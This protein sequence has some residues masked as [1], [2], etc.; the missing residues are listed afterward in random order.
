MDIYKNFIDNPTNKGKKLIALN[1]VKNMTIQPTVTKNIIM[2]I[3]NYLYLIELTEENINIDIANNLI[4]IYLD[5]DEENE[6]SKLATRNEIIIRGSLYQIIKINDI[7]NIEKIISTIK[8]KANFHRAITEIK[9]ITDLRKRNNQLYKLLDKLDNETINEQIETISAKYPNFIAKYFSASEYDKMYV[10]ATNLNNILVKNSITN[11]VNVGNSLYFVSVIQQY[12]NQN[13]NY[14]DYAISKISPYCDFKTKP[15]VSYK[16]INQYI[17]HLRASNFFQELIQI[18]DSGE[19]VAL[20]DFT[21]TEGKSLNFF[22]ILIMLA[23]LDHSNYDLLVQNIHLLYV[24]RYGSYEEIIDN[25]RLCTNEYNISA[26][27]IDI[28]KQNI[29]TVMIESDNI[30]YIDSNIDDNRCIKQIAFNNITDNPYNLD[31]Q[32][33]FDTTLYLT[34]FTVIKKRSINE[35]KRQNNNATI[36]GSYNGFNKKIILKIY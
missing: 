21:M 34:M 27:Y 2:N 14:N 18:L 35:I 26:K 6:L 17:Y 23:L 7:N 31:D 13:I 25:F 32:G 28:V 36:G 11:L 8:E 4:L 20:C 33:C 12:I 10:L 9:S 30:I 5:S 1:P 15:D 19:K 16:K 3:F 29:H 24:T 22:Y